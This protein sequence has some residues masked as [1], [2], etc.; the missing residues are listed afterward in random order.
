MIQ[1]TMIHKLIQT[2]FATH[3]T[4]QFILKGLRDFI[5]LSPFNVVQLRARLLNINYIFLL[6]ISTPLVSVASSII[7]PIVKEMKKHRGIVLVDVKAKDGS[8]V[9]V[10]L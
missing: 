9:K 6:L 4:V 3:F 10:R 2:I 1:N 8:E 5:S 7:A